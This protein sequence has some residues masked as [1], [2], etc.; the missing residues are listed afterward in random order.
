MTAAPPGSADEVLALFERRGDRHYGEDVTQTEH[1][2]QAAALARAS[3][4]PDH[5]VGAALLHDVGHLLDGAGGEDADGDD[6]H[7]VVGA[8]VLSAIF[9]PD[10]ARPVALHVVAKRW[11][12][13]VEA[14]Y[15]DSLSDA[16]RRSLDRQGGPLD[17]AAVARFAASPGFDDAIALRRWDDEAKVVGAARGRLEDHALLLASLAGAAR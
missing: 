15:L 14:E 6:H 7:E 16:S 9:G 13:A 11:R 2:L 1:A 4:A 3:G 5:L 8:R 12:C 17:P 10:V